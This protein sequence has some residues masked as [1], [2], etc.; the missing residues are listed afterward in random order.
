M[1]EPKKWP[2]DR[3]AFLFL[4]HFVFYKILQFPC[5]PSNYS[6]LHSSISVLQLN[7]WARKMVPGSKSFPFSFPLRLLKIP[8]LSCFASTW[9]TLISTLRWK[10]EKW[11]LDQEALFLVQFFFHKI[12]VRTI[13][14]LQKMEFK[15]RNCR[16]MVKCYS[17]IGTHFP[18]R[19]ELE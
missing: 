9:K 10:A 7:A 3:K 1:L 16:F 14:N 6:Q 13:L 18:I 19:S 2:L 17:T 8:R 11:T 12:A 4:F 15:L 5:F